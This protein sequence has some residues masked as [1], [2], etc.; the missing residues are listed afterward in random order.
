MLKF[1]AKRALKRFSEHYDFDVSYL[2]Y[3]LEH[4]PSAFFKFSKVSTVAMHC[5][6]APVAAAS[7]AALVGAIAED[8]GPCTQ[9]TVNMA[10]EAGM[11]RDQ[12]EAVL[13]R[14][15]PA[16]SADTAL[17]FRFA[18]AVV[19][20]LQE[21]DELRDAVR[22]Q[23]GEKGVIDLTLHLQMARL[24]PMVKAGLGYAKTCQRIE[25]AESPVDV[26]KEAA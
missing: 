17:G 20:D 18:N 14:N 8:C 10:I 12:I 25:I 21:L 9:L 1:F 5:E 11:G 24:Y 19:L 3:M 23:W 13:T 2:R 15:V 16:M 7:A 26:V 6:S 22:A 4:S